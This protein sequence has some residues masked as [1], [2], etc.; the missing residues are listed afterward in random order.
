MAPDF[1]GGAGGRASPD[2]TP[3]HSRATFAAHLAQSALPAL[4]HRSGGWGERKERC[5][6]LRLFPPTGECKVPLPPQLHRCGR[7]AAAGLRILLPGEEPGP[8][9]R[10]P[11]PA[12][13]AAP[14][15]ASGAGAEPRGGEQPDPRSGKG[16]GARRATSALL[17]KRGGQEGRTTTQHTI[18]RP[19]N[20]KTIASFL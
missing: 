8:P 6:F 3:L 13:G 1:T 16:A 19:D 7:V 5:A 18:P 12:A 2:R 11:A 20:P 17:E 9:G 10:P 15:Q 14:L 4:P